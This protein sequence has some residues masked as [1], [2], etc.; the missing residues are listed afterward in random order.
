MRTKCDRCDSMS[1]QVDE[2]IAA[3]TLH[4]EAFIGAVRERDELARR[5]EAP[6]HKTYDD[7]VKERDLL[8]AELAHEKILLG[9]CSIAAQ[10]LDKE[11]AR[12][13]KALEEIAGP[14]SYEPYSESQEL[15]RGALGRDE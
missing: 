3:N 7:V 5:L 12:L 14:D 1:A 11:N 4:Y 10:K 9:A 8:R 6:F 2:L 15:A 13:R